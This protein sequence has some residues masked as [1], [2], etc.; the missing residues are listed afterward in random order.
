M[1]WSL[2][3]QAY[4]LRKAGSLA[5]Y[6]HNSASPAAAGPDAYF[7]IDATL[8][9]NGGGKNAI[10]IQVYLPT[11][12]PLSKHKSAAPVSPAPASSSPPYRALINLH[13]GGFVIGSATDDARWCR[14]CTDKGFVVF[15]IEYRLAPSAP[16]P[17]PVED[18]VD[19]VLDLTSA[20]R[21]AEWSTV[22][23]E[24][25]LSGFSA[26]GNLAL[27]SW[28]VLQHPST[29]GYAI[30]S[31]AIPVIKGLALFY[32]VLDF[33]IP[34]EVKLGRAKRPDMAL[35]GFLVDLFDKSYLPKI[36]PSSTPSSSSTEDSSTDTATP[37]VTR[38][39]LR[40][41]PG[42]MPLSDLQ[43]LPPMHLIL[44]EWDTL[45]GEGQDLARAAI[46][47]GRDVRVRVVPEAKHGW[48]KPPRAPGQD[49]L[50]EYER[51]VQSLCEFGG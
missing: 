38:S 24:V 4:A 17:I 1:S 18:C 16:F 34:R 37:P 36:P 31:Q 41:S 21:S 51:A 33:S 48:D 47:A 14:F 20:S 2:Y 28:V 15:S 23:G 42:I 9:S 5:F 35:P 39:D 25:Y 6:A 30:D 32:P 12:H 3:A 43:I 49:V 46:D 8:G 44:C 40:L 29:W 27:A 11:S 26:G 7:I 13:G 50:V 22:K 45:L 10:G 19:A